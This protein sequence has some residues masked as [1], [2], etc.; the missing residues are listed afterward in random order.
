MEAKCE[1]RVEVIAVLAPWF[2]IEE[3]GR[4]LIKTYPSRCL[5]IWF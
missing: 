2:G 3:A 1:R 5:Y 4:T